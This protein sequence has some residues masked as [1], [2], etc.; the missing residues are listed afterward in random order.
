MRLN[1]TINRVVLA[2]IVTLGTCREQVGQRILR[3]TTGATT[4]EYKMKVVHT[5]G[6]EAVQLRIIPLTLLD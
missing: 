3:S 1:L 4:L 6:V 2:T 5:F